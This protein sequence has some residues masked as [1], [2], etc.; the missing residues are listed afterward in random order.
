MI[1]LAMVPVAMIPVI[2]RTNIPEHSLLDFGME[3]LGYALLMIGTGLRL[4]A[5]LYIGSRKSQQVVR[6]GPYSMCRNP[7]YLGTFTLVAGVA[8]IF[9]N[10]I[11]MLAILLLFVPAIILAIR[12]EEQ[13]LGEVFGQEYLAYCRQVPRLWPSFGQ[14]RNV[15]FLEVSTASIRKAALEVVWILAIPLMEDLIEMLH[16]H[17]ALPVLWT[18]RL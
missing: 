17:L 12:M 18:V 4:W 9:G 2:V 6:N 5:T 11:M 13:H 10:P 16:S 3:S 8:L 7:L 14:Y 1:R 15:E